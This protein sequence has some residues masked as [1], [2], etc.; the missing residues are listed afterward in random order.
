MIAQLTQAQ[1]KH[2]EKKVNEKVLEIDDFDN[3]DFNEEVLIPSNTKEQL[4]IKLT[5]EEMNIY[6]KEMIS[7]NLSGRYQKRQSFS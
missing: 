3:F 1:L 7:K 6:N 5:A 4:K 2:E